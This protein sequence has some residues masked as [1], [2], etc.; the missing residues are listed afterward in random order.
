M[1]QIASKQVMAGDETDRHLEEERGDD[2]AGAGVAV[3]DVDHRERQEDGGGVVAARFE[4]EHRAEPL[5][6]RDAA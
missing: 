4:F 1:I 2:A 5:L 3:D 6:H